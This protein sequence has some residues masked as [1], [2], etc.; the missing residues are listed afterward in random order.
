MK[1]ESLLTRSRA[2]G[3]IDLGVGAQ[4]QEQSLETLVTSPLLV[5]EWI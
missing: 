2:P 4:E 1:V 5:T 3:G